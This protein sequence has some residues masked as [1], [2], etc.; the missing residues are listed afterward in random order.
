MAVKQST[1]RGSPRGER[2]RLLPSGT[3]DFFRRRLIQA[4]GLTAGLCGLFLLIA[5]LTYNPADPSANRAAPRSRA[6]RAT[7]PP[8]NPSPS[9]ATRSYVGVKGRS[10]ADAS[11]S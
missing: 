1:L 6:A 10:P 7:E 4:A 9:T 8:S 3:G 5:C 2:A 11:A